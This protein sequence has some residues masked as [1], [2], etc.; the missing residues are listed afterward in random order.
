[1]KNHKQGFAGVLAIILVLAVLGLGGYVLYRQAQP[2]YSY[3]STTPPPALPEGKGAG[4]SPLGGGGEGVTTDSTA[5]WKT[6]KNDQFGFEMKYPDRLVVL[7]NTRIVNVY[8][9][10]PNNKISLSVLEPTESC[11]GGD[12]DKQSDPKIA[13]NGI[14]FY[15]RDFYNGAPGDE[16]YLV[17][18]YVGERGG[19]CYSLSLIPNFPPA[20]PQAHSIMDQILSTFRFTK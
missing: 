10:F 14:S 16:R 2:N 1:M 8:F 5:N 19:E 15:H 18:S 3:Q 20:Q 11:F 7:S 6:Y 13:L 4:A 12:I 9:E 17:H